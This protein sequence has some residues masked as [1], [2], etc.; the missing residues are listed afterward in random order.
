MDCPG[1]RLPRWLHALAEGAPRR[2]EVDH[3]DG[4][5]V[6]GG[7]KVLG[8]QGPLDVGVLPLCV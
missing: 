6:Q 1:G 8:G 4:V 7:V 5:A 3:H 2:V